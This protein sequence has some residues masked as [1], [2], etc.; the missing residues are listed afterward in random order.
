MSTGSVVTDLDRTVVLQLG[1]HPQQEL[2][3]AIFI[4]LND[5]WAE[6]ED[7]GSK[8]LYG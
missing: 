3:R 8:N 4:E 6:F 5:A 7:K 2:A 1:G